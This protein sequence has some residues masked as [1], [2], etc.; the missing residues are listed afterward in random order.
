METIKILPL[1]L[2]VINEIILYTIVRIPK[3]D[4]RYDILLT[5]PIKRMIINSVYVRFTNDKYMLIV[6]VNPNIVYYRFSNINN[7]ELLDNQE[8]YQDYFFW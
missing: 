2:D 1:P 4:Y 5:I 3:T 7:Y 8:F 6:T